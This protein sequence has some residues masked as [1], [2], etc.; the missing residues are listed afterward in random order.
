MLESMHPS[1]M[2]NSAATCFLTY[3]KTF[4]FALRQI[5]TYTHLKPGH[6]TIMEDI[7]YRQL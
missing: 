2:D 7:S 1:V 4:I 3:G 5:T 6:H